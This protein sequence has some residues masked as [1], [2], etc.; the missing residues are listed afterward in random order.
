MNKALVIWNIIITIALAGAV[1]SGCTTLDPQLAS[2]VKEVKEN[3]AYLEQVAD[4]ANQNREAITSMNSEIMKNALTVA[5]LQSTTEAAIAAVQAS[6][7]QY[8][9]Q[10]VQAY[11]A[12]A[13]Q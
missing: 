1:F 4:L 10:Y 12:E 9:Q 5:S 11:V 13:I 7:E 3:R 2:M 6:F 8:V